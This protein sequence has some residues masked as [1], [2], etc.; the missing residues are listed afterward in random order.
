MAI[1]RA[2]LNVIDAL[3]LVIAFLQFIHSNMSEHL[4]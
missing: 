1:S 3:F 4:L 2:F